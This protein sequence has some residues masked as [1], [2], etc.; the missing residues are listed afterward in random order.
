MPK[1]VIWVTDP[2]QQWAFQGAFPNQQSAF[3]PGHVARSWNVYFAHFYRN[4][5]I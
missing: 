2:A 4:C 1:N 3:Q 5:K